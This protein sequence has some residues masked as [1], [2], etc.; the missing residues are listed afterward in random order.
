[1]LRAWE[2]VWH[3]ASKQKSNGWA[4]VQIDIDWRSADVIPPGTSSF[5]ALSPKVVCSTKKNPPN[6]TINV[7][8]LNP[9]IH[10]EILH[11]GIAQCCQFIANFGEIFISGI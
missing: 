8:S 6:H 10:G 1:M 11:R 2:D 9:Y 4:G 5:P 3:F 7:F